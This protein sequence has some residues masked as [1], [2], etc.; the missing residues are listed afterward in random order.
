MKKILLLVLV[1]FGLLI[2]NADAKMLSYVPK[3]PT[4]ALIVIHGYGQ[5]GSSMGWMTE[6]FR[7]SIP[8]MAVFYPTA[9]KRGPY[10]GY[11]WFAVPKMGEQIKDKELYDGMMKDALKNVQTL[12]DLVDEIHNKHQ[13]PYQ[14]I[15]VSGFSQGGLMALLT[16]LTSPRDISIAISFSGV[17]LLFTPDFTAASVKNIPNIL[18]MQGT[19]DWVIPKDSLRMTRETL[20]ELNIEPTMSLI[21]DMS[22]QI[23]WKALKAAMDFIQ[24]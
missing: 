18:I 1:V 16:A 11:Q 7:K 9:P 14:K 22:H 3:N 23:S 20:T 24:Q 15:Y 2:G 19:N 21:P 12:H 13:I 5:K 8:D 4:Q 17:P 10:G 6:N